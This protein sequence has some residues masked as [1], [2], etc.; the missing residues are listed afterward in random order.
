[1]Y[2]PGEIQKSRNKELLIVAQLAVA[3]TYLNDAAFDSWRHEGSPAEMA[4][5]VVMQAKARGHLTFLQDALIPRD[6][7]LR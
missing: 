7:G 2:L 1:M 3:Y 5:Y 4:V 6:Y